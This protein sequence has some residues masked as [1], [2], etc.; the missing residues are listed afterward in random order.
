MFVVLLSFI[1]T[2]S[3]YVRYK[4]ISTASLDSLECVEGEIT[5]VKQH[6]SS[7]DIYIGDLKLFSNIKHDIESGDQVVIYYYADT[8]GDHND[9]V[10]IRKEED[11]IYLME[12]YIEKNNYVIQLN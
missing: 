2:N 4:Y 6:K 9:I 3:N 5:K 8:L 12:N 1:Y 7:Y 11:V 10:E